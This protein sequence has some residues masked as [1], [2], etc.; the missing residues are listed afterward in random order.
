MPQLYFL[1]P[2]YTEMNWGHY[3]NTNQIYFEYVGFKFQKLQKYKQ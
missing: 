1:C 3:K 2:N